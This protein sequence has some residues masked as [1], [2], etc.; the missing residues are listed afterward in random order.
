MITRHL[1][2]W[3]QPSD[4]LLRYEL[5]RQSRSRSAV[6]LWLER[7]GCVLL[8]LVMCGGGYWIFWDSA[9]YNDAPSLYETLYLPLLLIQFFTAT[10]PL[11]VTARLVIDERQRGAWESI[12]ITSH[13]AEHMIRAHWVTAF[14]RQRW[15]LITVLAGRAILVLR[16]LTDLAWR[17][18]GD[19]TAGITPGIPPAGA[20]LVLLVFV[21]GIM[22]QPLILVG[23]SAAV[24]V[25]LSTLL[26]DGFWMRIAL[27][28]I[29]LAGI[30]GFGWLTLVGVLAAD[31]DSYFAPYYSTTERW[32]YVLGM[33]TLADQ[34]LFLLELDYQV[35]LWQDLEYA[36]VLDIALAGALLLLAALT[37]NM[38]RWAAR[39]AGRP[40]RV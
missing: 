34:G 27:L 38:I 20:V 24:G 3:A 15:L 7:G 17:D 30:I 31:V 19:A 13:G 2:A 32:V 28:V 39:R 26:T 8:V 23:F 25:L 9:R 36:I 40:A 10:S 37:R 29:L 16:L 35:D 6:R 1:P 5:L 33:T 21:S 12:K 4:P 18:L 14:Y 22:V 11:M